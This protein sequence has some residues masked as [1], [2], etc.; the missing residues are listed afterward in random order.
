MMERA[1]LLPTSGLIELDVNHSQTC[2]VFRG[3]YC[4]CD[5]EITPHARP[6][7]ASEL[8]ASKPFSVE[9]WAEDGS[10]L[11][12]GRVRSIPDAVQWMNRTPQL[13]R[14]PEE[15]LLIRVEDQDH[16]GDWLY[17]APRDE[18]RDAPM[19]PMSNLRAVIELRKQGRN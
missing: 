13:C 15:R 5:P 11:A 19:P 14:T 12:F 2:G 3:G 17:V 8:E 16:N 4:D 6:A 1:G 18:P 10:F 7:L 9:V